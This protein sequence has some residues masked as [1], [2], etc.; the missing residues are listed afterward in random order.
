MEAGIQTMYELTCSHSIIPSVQRG[1]R[2]S[3]LRRSRTLMFCSSAQARSR[4]LCGAK[5]VF[6]G[7]KKNQRRFTIGRKSSCIECRREMP[8][9]RRKRHNHWMWKQ[10][11]TTHLQALCSD[12]SGKG[13]PR[14]F[15]MFVRQ[16]T[17]K[18]L[19]LFRKLMGEL[20]VPS[21]DRQ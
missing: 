20:K 2:D 15:G 11:E 8:Y 7:T 4:N 21:L 12:S 10:H 14:G 9:V 13:W 6:N 17:P 5:T 1:S 18:E 19:E 16:V 3:Y